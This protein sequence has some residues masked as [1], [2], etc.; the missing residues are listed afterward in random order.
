VTLGNIG[1]RLPG[2]FLLLLTVL[3]QLTKTFDGHSIEL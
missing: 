3:D 1:R 2:A